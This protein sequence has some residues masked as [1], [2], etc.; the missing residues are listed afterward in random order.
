MLFKKI[1]YHYVYTKYDLNTRDDL[2]LI[3]IKFFK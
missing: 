2:F 1:I 3:R